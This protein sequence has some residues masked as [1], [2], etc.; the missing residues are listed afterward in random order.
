MEKDF[1][2]LSSNKVQ[3]YEKAI[4]SYIEQMCGYTQLNSHDVPMGAGPALNMFGKPSNHYCCRPKYYRADVDKFDK[5]I[6]LEYETQE[7]PINVAKDMLQYCLD[8]IG[9]WDFQ[10][11]DKIL[12]LINNGFKFHVYVHDRAKKQEDEF[13]W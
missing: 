12:E 10:A 9:E 4:E 6:K 13:D 2:Q 5:T 8:T 7:T 11:E 1:S 3:A